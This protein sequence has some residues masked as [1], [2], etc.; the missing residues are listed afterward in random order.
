MASVTVILR[1]GE[2][3]RNSGTVRS[4]AH[5]RPGPSLHR[6]HPA[7]ARLLDLRADAAAAPLAPAGPRLPRVS[8]GRTFAFHARARCARHGHARVRRARD[9]HARCCERRRRSAHTA[10]ARAL[11]ACCCTTSGTA[12]SATRARPCSACATRSARTRFSRCPTMREGIEALDVD[13][14]DVLGTDRRR[15]EHARIRRCANS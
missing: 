6:A 11:R 1:P 9:R 8:V 15:S 7:E 14:A 10:P 13:P 2:S 5:L 4:E 12:R 3:R